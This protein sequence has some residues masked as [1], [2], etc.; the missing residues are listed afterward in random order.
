MNPYIPAQD[1]AF[2]AW[3]QNFDG[4]LSVDFAAFGVTAGEA[5]IITNVTN[6]FNVGLEAATAPITRTPVTVAAKDA[7]R[8]SAEFAVRPIAVRV[9]LDGGISNALKVQLGVTVRSTTPTPIPAPVIA[10]TI[11]LVKA[12]PLE[13]QLQIRPVGSSTKAKPAGV[14]AIEVAQSIGTVAATDPAQLAIIGQYGKTPL[15]LE[16]AAENRGK[17]VTLAARYRTRSGPAG[18]SQ[19]GPWSA[20]QTYAVV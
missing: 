20:L 11:A 16:Y 18:V 19:A 17:L 1:N 4:I 2:L 14:V 9:S 10:P 8:A 3:L 12:T 7:A 6:A 15:T 5:V 13:F